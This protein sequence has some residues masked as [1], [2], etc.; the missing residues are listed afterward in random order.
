MGKLG[1]GLGEAGGSHWF[2]EASLLS[3]VGLPEQTALLVGRV[4]SLN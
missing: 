4:L 3:A 1:A 2:W